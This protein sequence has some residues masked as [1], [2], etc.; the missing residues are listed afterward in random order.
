MGAGASVAGGAGSSVVVGC[1]VPVDSRASGQP[2][3]QLPPAVLANVAEA[4]KALGRL[5]TARFEFPALAFPGGARAL[6]REQ[7]DSAFRRNTREL[8]TQIL[9]DWWAQSGRRLVAMAE[10]EAQARKS[11]WGDLIQFVRESQAAAGAS[12]AVG[13]PAAAGASPDAAPQRHRQTQR[14]RRR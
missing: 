9:L 1:W 10:A 13:A 4:R 3:G 8:L 6:L 7:V 2:S 5:Y 14:G 12:A 11:T